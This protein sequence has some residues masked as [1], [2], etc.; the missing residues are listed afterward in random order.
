M[1]YIQQMLFRLPDENDPT[2][3]NPFRDMLPK[4]FVDSSEKALYEKSRKRITLINGSSTS[5]LSAD[6]DSKSEAGMKL[7]GHGV[8]K[9]LII[10]ESCELD[11]IT[12]TKAFRMLGDNPNTVLIELG[13]PWNRKHFYKSFNNPDYYKIKVDW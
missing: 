13:N 9:G 5:I 12:Y 11:D 6:A 4:T 8:G 10:D 3:V 1:K 2:D 7:M